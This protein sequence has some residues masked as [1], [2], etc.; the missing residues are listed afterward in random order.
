MPLKSD[1]PS[2]RSDRPKDRA[3]IRQRERET[4]PP[5][6]PKYGRQREIYAHRLAVEKNAEPIRAIEARRMYHME[7]GAKERRVMNARVTLDLAEFRK[8]WNS[9]TTAKEEMPY[10]YVTMPEGKPELSEYNEVQ[11]RQQMTIK[12]YSY[13][14]SRSNSGQTQITFFDRD[15][16]VNGWVMVPQG[17]IDDIIVN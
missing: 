11:N 6:A 4:L 15:G 10:R 8:K 17:R 2:V 13:A 5:D 9:S 12:A 3:L 7:K 14:T 1:S 16:N